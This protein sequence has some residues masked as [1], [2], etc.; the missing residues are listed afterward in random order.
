[1]LITNRD[2]YLANS[3]PVRSGGPL[4]KKTIKNKQM[5]V[6]KSSPQAIKT[7]PGG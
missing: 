2:D 6:D 7:L 1:M 3:L 5:K 4:A